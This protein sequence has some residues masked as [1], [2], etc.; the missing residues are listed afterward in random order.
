MERDIENKNET[1][2][3]LLLLPK[4]NLFKMIEQEKWRKCAQNRIYDALIW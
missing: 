2:K 3:M 1:I 4:I